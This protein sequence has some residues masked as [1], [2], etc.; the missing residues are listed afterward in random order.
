[1]LFI[2]SAPRKSK[3]FTPLISL[4]MADGFRAAELAEPVCS[5]SLAQSL[6]F[7]LQPPPPT[8][9]L[10]HPIPQ[11]AVQACS[12]CQHFHNT[13]TVWMET[14]ET[15]QTCQN[16]PFEKQREDDVTRAATVTSI[17]PRKI[18]GLI[19]VVWM[20][21]SWAIMFI[22]RARF[23]FLL[24]LGDC[25]HRG[26]RGGFRVRGSVAPGPSCTGSMFLKVSV[27][28]LNWC[29]KLHQINRRSCLESSGTDWS[30]SRGRCHQQ[31]QT[32]RAHRASRFYQ[33]SQG[34]GVSIDGWF[35]LVM[36]PDGRMVI[37]HVQESFSAA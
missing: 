12:V 14:G 21:N 26:Y 9:L 24:A 20:I 29:C 18:F 25:C 2:S 4:L 6:S 31:P 34:G 16:G 19:Q 23:F 1:M 27:Y 22:L 13:H 30:G 28:W 37:V 3:P 36:S 10:P 5:L 11:Q 17:V 15:T 8:F 33:D 35:T 32:L 7:F